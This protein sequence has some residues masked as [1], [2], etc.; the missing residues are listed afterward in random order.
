MNKDGCC[1]VIAYV[2]AASTANCVSA[3]LFEK[4]P[5]A[6]ASSIQRHH[7]VHNL[8][9][10]VD[11]DIFDQWACNAY[12]IASTTNRVLAPSFLAFDD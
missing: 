1:V 9:V 2:K 11:I 4:S 12:Q 3:P 10:K 8:L 7:L 5:T 6:M